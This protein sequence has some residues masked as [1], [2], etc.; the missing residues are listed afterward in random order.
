MV[1]VFGI[2]L[3]SWVS[4]V[5]NGGFYG[6][7]MDWDDYSVFYWLFSADSGVCWGEKGVFEIDRSFYYFTA[8]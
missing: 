2:V 4:V 5:I 7:R 3:R 6:F 8:L 1:Y